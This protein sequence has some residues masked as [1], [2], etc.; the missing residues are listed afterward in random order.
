[1]MDGLIAVGALVV[2]GVQRDPQ[3]THVCVKSKSGFV[4]F[5]GR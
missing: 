3:N 5:S 2:V 1:M 4:G